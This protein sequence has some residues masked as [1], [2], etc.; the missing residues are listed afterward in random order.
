MIAGV[1]HQPYG[2]DNLYTRE[3][4][5]RSPRDPAASQAVKINATTWP[6]EDG[7]AVWLAWTKNG[8]AQNDVA[9]QWQRSDGATSYWQAVFGPFAHA[10][11]ISYSVLANQNQSNQQQIGPFRF[12]ATARAHVTRV[13]GHVDNGTSFD[14]SL[15]ASDNAFTPKLRLAFATPD[16]LRVQFSP[17]G[18]GLTSIESRNYTLSEQSD[19]LTLTT[20][21]LDVV[22]EKQPYRLRLHRR[23]DNTPTVQEIDPLQLPSLVWES[24]DAQSINRIEECLTTSPAE[25]IYGFGERYDRFDQ[26]GTQIET[27]I[28]NEYGDQ[29]ATRRTYLA[30]PFFLNSAGY[31]LHLASTAYSRFKLG[32]DRPDALGIAVDTR[33]MANALLDYQIFTGSPRRILDRYTAMAGR[34]LLPPKWCFGLWLSA[35]EW[36]NQATVSR[37]MDAAEQ[38]AIP[39]TALVLEQWSDEATYYCWY[40]A[41][42]TPKPGSDALNYADFTFPAGG[43]WPDPK[44]MVADAHRRGIRV[45]L[46]QIPILQEN[47]PPSPPH[48]PTAAP[49]QLTNDK[50]YAV[51]QGYVVGDGLGSLARLPLRS[52]KGGS[53]VPDFTNP[54]AVDWWMSKRAYLIDEVKIDGFKCDGGE[55]VFSHLNVFHDGRHGALMHNAY[56]GAYV[57]AYQAFVSTKLGPNGAV[58]SRA[59]ST[60]AQA[61]S[62]YWAGDQ[63]S[64]FEALQSAIRAG[65]SA[66][67]SGVPYWSWDLAGFAGPFPSAE[68]YLRSAAMATFC[69]VMQLHGQWSSPETSATRTPWHVQAVTGD[70][71]VIPVFAKFANLRM[72]LLPYIYSEAKHAALH[73]APMMRAMAIDYPD[74][75]VAASLDEQYLFGGQMVVGPVTTEGA[76][77]KDIYIPRG[78]WWDFWNS[79]PF[80]GPRVKLYGVPIDSL[81]V[82]ARPGAII[83]LNLDDEFEL[84][85]SVG[86]TVE[87]VVNLVFR[88]HPLGLTSYDYFDDALNR[89]VTITVNGQWASRQVSVLVPAL[90]SGLYLQVISSAPAVVNVD[91]VLLPGFASLADVRAAPQGWYWDPALQACLMKLAPSMSSRLVVASGVDKAAY[92]AEFADA[93]GAGVN[94]NHAGFTG[95]GFVDGFDSVGDAITFV[96]NADVDGRHQLAFRYANAGLGAAS[97]NVYV[98]GALLGTVVLPALAT[99]DSWGTAGIATRLTAGRHQVRMAFDDGNA[100]PINVDSLCLVVEAESA[101]SVVT[102]HNNTNRT[103]ANLHETLL[104]T[105]NVAGGRFGKLFSYPVLGQVFAQPLY[106]GGLAMA[107]KGTHNVVF[108]ATMN[109]QVYAFDADDALQCNAP[110]W[111]RDLGP[112]IKLPDAGIGPTFIGP[113]KRDTGLPIKP[114]GDPVYLDIQTEVGVLSTPVIS[115]ELNTM[116]VVSARKDQGVPGAAAYAHELHALDLSTGAEKFGG[117]I[118]INAS[119][120]G[121]GYVGEHDERDNV[122][123]GR[124]R[125]VSHRQLQRAGLLLASGA[126]HIAFASYGDRDCYHGWVLAYD[127]HTL[128]QT[129]VFNATPNNLSADPDQ[130]GRAGIWQAGAGLAADSQAIYFSTGNG[131]YADGTDFGDCFVKLRLGDLKV[132]DWFSPFNQ[133]ALA[134]NDI[135]LGSSGVLL[136]PGNKLMIGGGKESKFFLMDRANLGHFDANAG[137]SQ[138]LQNFYVHAPDNPKDPIRSARKYDGSGHHIHGAPAY[139]NGPQGRWIY[140]WAEVDVVKAFELLPSGRFETTP[141]TLTGIPN[142]TLGVP[143]SRGAVNGRGG[144]PGV[145]PG[146]PGGM[147]SISANAS[148]AGTGILW[149]THPFANANKA[150]VPG[151]IRAF[152]ASDL[153]MELWNSELNGARDSLG[154]YAKFNAP[155]IANGKVYVATFAGTV[156]AYGLL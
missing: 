117:P 129:A 12:V 112:S 139:W 37:E 146:M 76:A 81:P 47:F 97:R 18:L 99:W 141:I 32:T 92:G 49:P 79:C 104:T 54:N 57:G 28:Y 82:F 90:S 20:S 74:D 84:G 101:V 19:R 63:L 80:T 138:I 130:V 103:G 98:D 125:F 94:S 124:I 40:G 127:A 51:Q 66:G 7:Q 122:S 52:W 83:P 136:V 33:G 111:H 149:A 45:V 121:A 17:T 147:V 25:L 96:V 148:S 1:Y 73:G 91:G 10:D 85:G 123:N 9:A 71:R 29:A 62:I 39:V 8:I 70:A 5:E 31:A 65:L 128:Q 109:N 93:V 105:A 67:A 4:T 78:E 100:L 132:L 144:V 108:I 68:L 42:Y 55:A 140:I 134:S 43:A 61:L 64:S 16:S 153:S 143:A 133:E 107:G 21:E 38:H 145:P 69:P 13:T 119:A 86:N 88:I 75:A 46:W 110:L 72:N 113:D 156:V 120:K 41:Q 34:P 87:S 135:D 95:V 58:F 30:I 11:V 22:I 131:G 6:V 23:G 89:I 24:G 155:T 126:V 48:Y 116:Y 3:A 102:Q 137:N 115:R 35:N 142:A 114:N 152:D 53:L 14:L 15:A 50:A 2:Y 59:G 150:V 60:G 106:A 36:N 154:S 27:F 77:V 56:A 151:V 118:R 44:A 26:Q